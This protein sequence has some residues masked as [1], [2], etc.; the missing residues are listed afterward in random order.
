MRLAASLLTAALLA[1]GGAAAQPLPAVLGQPALISPRAAGSLLLGV[2]LAGR[3]LVA[4]GERGIVL[5]SDDDGATWRQARLVPAAVTLTAVRFAS[6]TSGW[7][8][9][10]LG[11]VLHTEDGGE[12]WQRQLDGGQAAALMLAAA[13]RMPA[14]EARTAA[15][16]NAAQLVKD[17]ADKPFLDLMLRGDAILAVGA[18]GLAV[19]SQDGGR[20]WAAADDIADPQALNLYAIVRAGG[21]T[22]VAGEQGFLAT[23]PDGGTFRPIRTPYDGTFFGILALPD[24]PAI[25]F[26]LAGALIRREPGAAE[27]A[28]EPTGLSGAITCAV[29][30]PDARVLLATD[31]GELAL[32]DREA[33]NYRPLSLPQR[34]PVTAMLVDGTELILTGPTGPRRLAIV[35]LDARS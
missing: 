3:R 20:S 17:G 19:H 5:L 30:L 15:V 7:A 26:G 14:G 6:A 25:A 12:T 23:A 10:H 29:A 2:A 13:G 11:I 16:G 24:G 21:A 22:L 32:G 33:R 18:Y 1:G 34:I 35:R 4:V 27:W 9:G 8:V 28:M 31:S